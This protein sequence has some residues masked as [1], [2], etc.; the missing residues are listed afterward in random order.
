MVPLLALM[1]APKGFYKAETR[2][3]Q[4]VFLL[5]ASTSPDKKEWFVVDTGAPDSVYNG[6][7]PKGW[8]GPTFKLGDRMFGFPTQK[9]DEVA[10]GT[11]PD[12]TVHISGVIGCDFLKNAQL[13]L[14]YEGK[15]LWMRPGLALTKAEAE[16]A[17]RELQP[18]AK[19]DRLAVLPLEEDEGRYRAVG[20]LGERPLKWAFDTGVNHVFSEEARLKAAKALPL[21]ERTV[22]RSSGPVGM[23]RW[24]VSKVEVGPKRILLPPVGDGDHYGEH[25]VVGPFDFARRVL[26]DLPGKA[27]YWLEPTGS[28]AAV[29]EAIRRLAGVM[30]RRAPGGR[31]IVG[32]SLVL[33]SVQGE[34]VASLRKILARAASGDAKALA[35]VAA[36]YRSRDKA[37]RVMVSGEGVTFAVPFGAL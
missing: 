6:D 15:A 8:P 14:D 23:M 16:A 28:E 7:L 37:P 35:R 32:K 12:G 25:G 20:H 10:I 17:L 1:I 5:S 13:L 30:L 22:T 2:F 34:S 18:G 26:V 4:G 27:V 11:S 21:T 36:L 19:A 31:L 33:V 24:L 29:D 3:M 9:D